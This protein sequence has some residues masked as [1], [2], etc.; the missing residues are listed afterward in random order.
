MPG[1]CDTHTI[2]KCVSLSSVS[3]SKPLDFPLDLVYIEDIPLISHVTMFLG[4]GPLLDTVCIHINAHLITLA[5]DLRLRNA[6]H[7]RLMRRSD[8]QITG[9]ISL[10]RLIVN[11]HETIGAHNIR[12]G[13]ISLFS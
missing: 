4:G 1:L 2:R 5:A 6:S 10:L 11:T 13:V 7:Y 9:S 12:M 3:M 8:D